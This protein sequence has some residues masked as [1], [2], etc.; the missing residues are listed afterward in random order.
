MSA[1]RRLVAQAVGKRLI[2]MNAASAPQQAGPE[3]EE[4]GEVDDASWAKAFHTAY[5]EVVSYEKEVCGAHSLAVE[6]ARR[7]WM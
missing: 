6:E 7:W 3:E 4:E 2:A 5:R 1:A